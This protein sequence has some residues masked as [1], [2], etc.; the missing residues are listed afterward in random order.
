MM[1][2]AAPRTGRSADDPGHG[3]VAP[4]CNVAATTA[5]RPTAPSNIETAGRSVRR[6]GAPNATR[7]P[8]PSSQARVGKE[9]NAQGSL[10][11]V[12]RRQSRNEQMEPR[13]SSTTAPSVEKRLS[14]Q[15]HDAARNKTG[16]TRYICSSTPS[17]Q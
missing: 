2:P 14:H 7:P 12:S 3:V 13:P 4:K 15:R 8:T 11:D 1:T 16:Q 6:A 10:L 9:K 5:A 17:D